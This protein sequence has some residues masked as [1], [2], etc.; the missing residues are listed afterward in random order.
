MSTDTETAGVRKVPE[1]FFRE[2][3]LEELSPALLRYF[4]SIIS[5]DWNATLE[6]KIYEQ[7]SEGQKVAFDEQ[8]EQIEGLQTA[9]T[10]VSML[11]KPLE[12][13][14]ARLLVKKIVEKQDE[15][16]PLLLRKYLTSRVSNFIENA[17]TAFAWADRKY[18]EELFHHYGEIQSLYAQSEACVAFGLKKLQGIDEFLLGE[19]HR[20]ETEPGAEVYLKQGPLVALN[21]I[22]GHLDSETEFYA[23]YKRED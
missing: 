23:H 14:N 1:K 2:H 18:T 6:E 9:E 16:M 15:A 21:A 19:F 20:F 12:T 7:R 10:M 4:T 13:A 17:V 8:R 3:Q 22:H 5:D 11:R